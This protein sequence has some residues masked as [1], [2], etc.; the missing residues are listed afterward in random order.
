MGRQSRICDVANVPPPDCI[1]G[2]IWTDRTTGLQDCDRARGGGVRGAVHGGGVKTCVWCVV[3]WWC[4]CVCV[5]FKMCVRVCV[6]MPDVRGFSVGLSRSDSR[7]PEI[8]PSA[9]TAHLIYD[10]GFLNGPS[11]RTV[12]RAQGRVRQARQ[13][14]GLALVTPPGRKSLTSKTVDSPPRKTCFDKINHPRKNFT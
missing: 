4:V 8:K 2:I 10:A 5:C 14:S 1:I 3:R 7:L 12:R 13:Y 11:F 6:G 9:Q